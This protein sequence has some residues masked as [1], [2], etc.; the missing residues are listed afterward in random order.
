M[1]YII[2]P[3]NK[4]WLPNNYNRCVNFS[5]QKRSAFRRRMIYLSKQIEACLQSNGYKANVSPSQ[6]SSALR[7]EKTFI[8]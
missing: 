5:F 2:Q 1:S 8:N 4:I 6:L 3:L 7:P